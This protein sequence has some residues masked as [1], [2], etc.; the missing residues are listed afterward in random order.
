MFGIKLSNLSKSGHSIFVLSTIDLVAI[1]AV[2]AE[3]DASARL[4]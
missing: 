2:V 1:N 3:A 4:S